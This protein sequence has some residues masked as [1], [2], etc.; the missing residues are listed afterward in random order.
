VREADFCGKRGDGELVSSEPTG[1]YKHPN[2]NSAENVDNFDN[3]GND[4]F[5]EYD[6]DLP[7]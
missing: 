7:F 5:E 2:I 1:N 4:D 6:G 3:V